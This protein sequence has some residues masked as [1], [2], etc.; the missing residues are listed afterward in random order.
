MI[1]YEHIHMNTVYEYI[2]I[3][4]HTYIHVY[5]YAY[6]YIH[7]YIYISSQLGVTVIS[8]AA[9]APRPNGPSVLWQ[10]SV[11]AS[12]MPSLMI[13]RGTVFLQLLVE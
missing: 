5:I 3:Y 9:A 1:I 2:Y 11:D 10:K 8:M 4:I 6:I 13:L 7:I 12:A